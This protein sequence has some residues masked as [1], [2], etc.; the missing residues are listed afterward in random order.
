MKVLIDTSIWSLAL[1]RKSP[2]IF[3]G[4]QVRQ[5]VLEGRGMIIGPIRQELL[6]G[7]SNNSQFALLRTRLQAFEDIDLK[8]V[9]YVNAAEICNA[10]R[11]KGVAA[12]A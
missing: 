8:T 9:H 4:N 3:I 6:S 1:R 10:C 7:I 5:L 11:M 12:M 2:D